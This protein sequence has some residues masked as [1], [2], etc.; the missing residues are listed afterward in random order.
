MFTFWTDKFE[1]WPSIQTN[2]RS[3]FLKTDVRLYVWV[4]IDPF[5]K[6]MRLPWVFTDWF[7]FCSSSY[8]WSRRV[9]IEDYWFSLSLMIICTTWSPKSKAVVCFTCYQQTEEILHVS[10]LTIQKQFGMVEQAM[11]N[12]CEQVWETLQW[13]VFAQCSFEFYREILLRSGRNSTNCPCL[14]MLK[15]ARW[16]IRKFLFSCLD[17]S[18]FDPKTRSVSGVCLLFPQHINS[19]AVEAPPLLSF[20]FCPLSNGKGRIFLFVS[21]YFSHRKINK[22]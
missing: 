18:F 5:D 3:V 2:T 21:E 12:R 1:F 10:L 16:G 4:G 7:T 19:F 6:D 9:L 11:R 8:Y 20:S 22:T 13:W 15:L 17:H 14:L